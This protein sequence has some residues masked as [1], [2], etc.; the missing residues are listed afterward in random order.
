MSLA[1]EQAVDLKPVFLKVR[2]EI[3]H[4]TELKK[5]L[6]ASVHFWLKPLGLLAPTFF[7]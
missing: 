7:F 6:G 3:P 2:R 1:S 5:S 4:E